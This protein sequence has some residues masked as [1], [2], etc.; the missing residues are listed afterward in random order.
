M[1]SIVFMSEVKFIDVSV[2]KYKYIYFPHYCE[3]KWLISMSL[4]SY[5]FP[6]LLKIVVE[7][8]V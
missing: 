7:F 3:M 4:N 1:L 8:L 5:M 6:A 2:V